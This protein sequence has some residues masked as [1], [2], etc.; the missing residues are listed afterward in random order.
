M[1]TTNI[2]QYKREK[3]RMGMRKKQLEKL[4][5]TKRQIIMEEKIHPSQFY[6]SQ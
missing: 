5:K 6:D 4:F 3:F 1:N 2:I